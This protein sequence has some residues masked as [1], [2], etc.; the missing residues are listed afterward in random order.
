MGISSD[1]IFFYGICFKDE[2]HPW[3]LASDEELKEMKEKKS[4]SDE[5][6]WEATYEVRTG[7]KASDSPVEIDIHCSFECSMYL[8]AIRETFVK[9]YRGDPQKAKTVLVKPEWGVQL[10]RFCE[11]MGIPWQEPG[12][13]VTSLYG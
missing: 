13:W 12:W 5:T 4:Y 6:D 8:V 10:R 7:K 1:G 3:R 11:T 2:D 9:A